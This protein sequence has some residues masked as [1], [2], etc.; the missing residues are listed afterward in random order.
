MTSY[1]K[2][3]LAFPSDTYPK[4]IIRKKNGEVKTEYINISKYTKPLRQFSKLKH[5][6]HDFLHKEKGN[7]TKLWINLHYIR[8]IEYYLYLKYYHTEICQLSYNSEFLKWI[9][10]QLSG[11][12]KQKYLR[13]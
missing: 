9:R 12:I 4:K 8:L 3:K 11:R 10:K 13:F 5:E 6:Y 7:T 1:E 2:V